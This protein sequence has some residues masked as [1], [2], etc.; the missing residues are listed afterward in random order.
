MVGGVKRFHAIIV[1]TP[2]FL[3]GCGNDNPAEHF[4][5]LEHQGKEVERFEATQ[6]PAAQE[7]ATEEEV[8]RT[9]LFKDANLEVVLREALEKPVGTITPRDL[10]SLEKFLLRDREIANLTGLE[11]ATKLIKLN[12]HENQIIDTTPLA[13]LTKLTGLG[14]G[15]NQI[16]DVAPLKGLIN[17][18]ELY[19]AGNQITDLS[20]LAGLTQLSKLNLGDNLITNITILANLT[21]LTRLDVRGNEITDA[22]PLVGLTKL[23]LLDLSENPIP[24]DQKNMLRKALPNCSISF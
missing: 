4:K 14:L 11:F 5:E 19:L 24:D 10:A 23:I 9:T 16:T 6:K 1:V 22:M 13:G 18:T 8:P 21:N 2:L 15:Y 20:Q 3:L 12:L 7:T 17:L